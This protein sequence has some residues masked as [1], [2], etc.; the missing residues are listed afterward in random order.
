M[1]INSFKHKTKKNNL[2]I[3][4][5][6]IASLSKHKEELETILNMLDF[7]FDIIGLTE[8]KIRKHKAPIFDI[9]L[10]GYK[11]CSTPTESENGRTILYIA[12]NYNCKPR[13]DLD[14]LLYKSTVF[15]STF[16]E[17]INHGKKT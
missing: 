11:Q 1:D 6:N 4:H 17:I 2:S 12:K 3:F 8:T 10:K 7:K 13:K 14:S 15:E 5:L 16:I 9:T